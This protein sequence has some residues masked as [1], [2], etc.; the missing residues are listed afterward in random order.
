MTSVNL[1][2]SRVDITFDNFR[3]RPSVSIIF[4]RPDSTPAWLQM[5]DAELIPQSFVMTREKMAQADIQW[6]E[7]FVDF[8][9]N[10]VVSALSL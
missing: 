4:P 5:R 3:V 6:S 2:V 7:V 8:V 1:Y 10:A 9:T